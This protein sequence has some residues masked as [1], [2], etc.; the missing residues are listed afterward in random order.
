[1]LKACSR[2]INSEEVFIRTFAIDIDFQPVGKFRQCVGQRSA[3][4]LCRPSYQISAG[5]RH[6]TLSNDTERL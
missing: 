1:M 5:V 3:I 2:H 4:L 6:Q